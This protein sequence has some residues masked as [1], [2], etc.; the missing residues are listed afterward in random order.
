[1]PPPARAMPTGCARSGPRCGA[2][3]RASKRRAGARRRDDAVGLRERTRPGHRRGRPPVDR[4]TLAG[5]N[6]IFI[7]AKDGTTARELQAE[8]ASY[9]ADGVRR[10]ALVGPRRWLARSFR[11]GLSTRT[12]P[13]F[14]PTTARRASSTPGGCT[15]P[16]CCRA[17]SW[18]RPRSLAMI[19]LDPAGYLAEDE[20]VHSAIER[21]LGE[22]AEDPCRPVAER[23][24]RGGVPALCAR[25]VRRSAQEIE[26]LALVVLTVAEAEADTLLPGYTH[27]QRGQPVTLGH[28]LL[29]WV[30]MLDRDRSRF[31]AAAVAATESPLG[32]GALAGSTLGLPAPP[33]Q[34]RNS[35]DA[36][37][38]RDFALD[39]LYAVAVLIPTS[40]G[41]ARR[42]CSGRR[43]SSASSGCRRTLPRGRR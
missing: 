1:M 5:D 4:G 30:E 17:T 29:A 41:S 18:P 22:W 28:H 23:P 19:A 10:D 9:L 8:L 32:A 38:D 35:I 39:Y 24:G 31:A 34:M 16:A 6:T 25:R 20:D 33:G 7:A 15:A 12:T 36:V 40:H 2:T 13:S 43:A 14:S 11:L 3:P 42:S 37:A 21:Q 27:L 26:A